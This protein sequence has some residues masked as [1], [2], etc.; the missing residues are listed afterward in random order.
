MLYSI[1]YL[2]PASRD[3]GR[4]HGGKVDFVGESIVPPFTK[5]YFRNI[6]KWESILSYTMLRIIYREINVNQRYMLLSEVKSVHVYKY[7]CISIHIN[8]MLI[9]YIPSHIRD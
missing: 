5:E 8:N 7:M 6:R 1:L 2:T 9:I 3:V 4:G